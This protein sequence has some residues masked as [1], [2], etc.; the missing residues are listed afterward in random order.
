[1]WPGAKYLPDNRTPNPFLEDDSV[2][3]GLRETPGF[4]FLSLLLDTI[5]AARKFI[6]F[7]VF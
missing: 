7:K 3:E 4:Y 1:M 2:T 5:Y 6:I